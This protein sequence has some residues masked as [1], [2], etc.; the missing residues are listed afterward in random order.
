MPKVTVDGVQ[1]GVPQGGTRVTR[2]RRTTKD[3]EEQGGDA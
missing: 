3:E 1:V 2:I